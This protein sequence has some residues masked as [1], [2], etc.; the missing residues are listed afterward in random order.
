MDKQ[1]QIAP[2]F[3]REIADGL[4]ALYALMLDGHPAA[5]ILSRTADVW[6]T[7]LWKGRAWDA[8][9]DPPRLREAFRRLAASAQRWPHPAQLIDRLPQ[10]RPQR[11]LPAPQISDEQRQANIRKLRSLART[12]GHR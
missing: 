6:E 12:I 2:W 8:D 1:E 5:D 3:R 7:A 9:L 10:R 11:A 4:S